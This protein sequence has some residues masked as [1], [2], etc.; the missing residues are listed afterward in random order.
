ML[1]IIETCARLNGRRLC[2]TL[3]YRSF[4]YSVRRGVPIHAAIIYIAPVHAE[5]IPIATT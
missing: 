4:Y 1:R 5:W 3:S 2:D